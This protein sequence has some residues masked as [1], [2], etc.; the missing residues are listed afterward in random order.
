MYKATNKETGEVT[1]MTEAQVRA[2]IVRMFQYDLGTF[3]TD[4]EIVAGV[5]GSDIQDYFVGGVCEVVNYT[6]S[7]A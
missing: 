2:E 5:A 3:E 4:E 1:E 7:L 6:I